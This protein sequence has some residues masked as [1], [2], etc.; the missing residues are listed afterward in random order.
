[1]THKISD[2]IY[3]V[4]LFCGAGGLSCGLE[5]AGA[6]CLLGIDHN[7][8]ALKTFEHN[9]KSAKALYSSI[10]KV[11]ESQIQTI[12]QGKTIDI[13]AG[14]PP[15]QGFSTVGMGNP[16]DSRNSLFQEYV[17]IL[18][19]L[20]PKYFIFENVT[21]ILAKKNTNTL[22][23][24]FQ[25]FF[26]Q[27][28]LLS[29][30]VLNAADFGIPQ[31]RRRT[32]IM[33][34]KKP[35]KL[36]SFP[37]PEATS[38]SL[39]MALEKLNSLKPEN[40]FNHDIEK[41]KI[42]DPLLKE[43]MRCIP[44]GGSVRYKADE[45][46]YFP[47]SL[48]LGL[49]WESLPE[50]RLREERFKRPDTKGLSSTITATEQSFFHPTQERRFTTRELATIQ[51][52]PFDFVFQGPY[53]THHKQIGNAV[54]PLLAKKIG[55]EIIK[56]ILEEKEKE[57]KEEKAKNTSF[58]KARQHWMEKVEGERKFAF[59]YKKEDKSKIFSAEI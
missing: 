58:N 14:G 8:H 55:T 50:K 18:K 13:L 3:F 24:I 48:R 19:I 37:S 11:T 31:Q 53:S 45:E 7:K 59:I 6:T 32:F 49:D 34:V 2:P 54:P 12:L 23:A 20:S 47:P 40:L 30:K 38:L 57:K 1:M 22:D 41:S 15:C 26:K 27:G 10:E 29:L 33:G 42:T 52:F 28:Y 25:E 35:F 44:E 51:S 36:P 46:K 39:G 56:T 5:Q 9:H 4:D 16:E 17:R 43:R 21:G